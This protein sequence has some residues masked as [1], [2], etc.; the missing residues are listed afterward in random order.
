MPLITSSVAEKTLHNE[1]KERILGL[2]EVRLSSGELRLEPI[3][4][5]S[6]DRDEFSQYIEAVIAI[7]VKAGVH[8]P[9]NIEDFLEVSPKVITEF[10]PLPS[11][12]PVSCA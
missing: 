8:F 1:F 12:E 10:L 7:A 2:E 6:L 5:T 4:T 11:T 3:S 9:D